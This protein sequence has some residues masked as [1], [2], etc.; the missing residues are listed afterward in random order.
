MREEAKTPAYDDRPILEI[1]GDAVSRWEA[2]TG[3][4]LDGGGFSFGGLGVGS[5]NHMLKEALE[6]DPEGTT[7]YLLLEVFLRVFLEQKQF[8]AAQIMKDYDAT[9][10]F[11]RDAEGL[12][13]IVQGER[14]LE[15]GAGFRARVVEGLKRY[16]ADRPDVLDVV[17][18]PNVI[19]FLRRDA[20]RSLK[21]LVPYQFLAG[22]DDASHPQAI[23]HVHMAWSINDMLAATRDMPVS[24]IAV[25][26][27]RDASKPDRSYFSFV[28][29]N[30]GNVI[31]FTDRN[32]PAYPGQ[33]DVL[34]GRGGRGDARRFAERENANHFPYQI[35]PTSYDE[36]GELVFDQETAPVAEGIRLV[37]L[38][39]IADLPP[40][41]AIWVTMMLSLVAEKFWTKAWRAPELSYTGEMIR[42]RSLLVEDGAGKTL[43]VATG[44]R[45]IELEDVRLEE[46]SGDAMA[47]QTRYK[48]EGINQ[49][50]EDRYAD[51]V[52]S[53]VLNAWSVN[54][55]DMLLLPRADMEKG[56]SQALQTN[57]VAL[58]GGLYTMKKADFDRLPFWNQPKSYKLSTFS[59]ADFGTE[60]ELRQDRLFIARKNQAAF[61]QKCTDEEFEDRKE[62]VLDW[63]KKAVRANLTNIL[64]L[65]E[66]G[67]DAPRRYPN[68]NRRSL[69]TF[70]EIKDE[71]IFDSIYGWGFGFDTCFGEY[72][73]H[74]GQRWL[75]CI[76]EARATYRAAFS[77]RDLDDLMLLTGLPKAKI[78][79]VLHAWGG[80]TR[81]SGNH[82]LSRIDPMDTDVSNPWNR[83]KIGLYV[84]VYLSKRGYKRLLDGKI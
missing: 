66:E 31:V 71:S 58:P 42:H 11:L 77:P 45:P 4:S 83:H 51:R 55:D 15:L 26:L 24:G 76:T 25:V 48:P 72:I 54:H 44:Y 80:K 28:M 82:L 70:G 32:K 73:S 74:G 43:P 47:E 68:G 61:I 60:E 53:E 38:M 52:P 12:F 41:Q 29:R 21:D 27:M 8:T 22:E 64:R 79:D 5:M 50:L 19:P 57:A 14:A 33:E 59:P 67:P 49:W 46:L 7:A 17:D 84:N 10:A 62:E 37:P 63:Y 6:L 78:P 39:A 20:L 65:V 56:Q 3:V 23:H 2:L 69:M 1:L 30:G 81:A 9:T 13:S 18:D 34:S 36:D 35:I 75:C 40:T 16:G